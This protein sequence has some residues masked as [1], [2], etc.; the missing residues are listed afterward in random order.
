MRIASLAV[1]LMAMLLPGCTSQP[2]A[3]PIVVQRSIVSLAVP[4]PPIPRTVTLQWQNN[5]TGNPEVRTGI[6]SSTNIVAPMEE[7]EVLFVTN[8]MSATNTFNAPI[9]NQKEFFRAF[10]FYEPKE[11]KW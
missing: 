9:V 1:S 6:A 7:W 11:A 2:A 3:V 10:N 4:Q 5:N 8:C